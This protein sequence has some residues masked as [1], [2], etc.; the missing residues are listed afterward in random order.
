MRGVPGNGPQM[1]EEVPVSSLNIMHTPL[2][3]TPAAQN[4][5][6]FEPQK[7][8]QALLIKQI[9]HSSFNPRY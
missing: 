7:Q 5:H 9:F 1:T 3:D 4:R 2:V 8:T 6:N